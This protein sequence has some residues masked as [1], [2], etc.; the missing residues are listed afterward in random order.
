MRRCREATGS[1]LWDLPEIGGC[2]AD[3]LPLRADAADLPCPCGLGCSGLAGCPGS[4]ALRLEGSSGFTGY[5]DAASP[6]RDR[7]QDTADRASADVR[8]C[9]GPSEPQ[10]RRPAAADA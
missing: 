6:E 7:P 10:C 9:R 2:D 5:D 3:G 8:Q 4:W 1:Y